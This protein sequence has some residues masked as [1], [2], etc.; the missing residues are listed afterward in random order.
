MNTPLPINNSGCLAGVQ[1]LFGKIR[2]YLEFNSLVRNQ[3]N[4]AAGI[5]CLRLG[6]APVSGDPDRKCAPRERDALAI[7]QDAGAAGERIDS[8]IPAAN[9]VEHDLRTVFQLKTKPVPAHLIGSQLVAAKLMV[10]PGITIHGKDLL[11]QPQRACGLKTS[12]RIVV[13]RLSSSCPLPAKPLLTVQDR[14]FE[15]PE[16]KIHLSTR[17]LGFEDVCFS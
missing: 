8:T 10:H 11:T 5:E 2:S 4:P 14:S 16:R 17:G 15:G 6:A 1:L 13:G 9:L 3:Q 7:G 12:Q